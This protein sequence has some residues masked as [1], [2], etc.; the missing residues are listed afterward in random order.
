MLSAT[1]APGL[2]MLPLSS[3]A[4][5]RTVLEGAP[6]AIQVNDHELVPVAGRQVAP[7]SVDTST[8]P[9]TPPP[10]SAAVPEIVTREPSVIVAPPTGD[11]IDDVG[12]VVSTDLVATVTSGWGVEGCTP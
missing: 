3:T 1:P 11:E 7:P 10:V 8:P 4:R 2:S 5:V 6:W 9:T 12:A